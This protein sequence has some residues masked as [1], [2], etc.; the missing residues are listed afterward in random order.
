MTQRCDR[1]AV[2]REFKP[3][4]KVMVLLPI[5]GSALQQRCTGSYRVGEVNYVIA[6]PDRRKTSRLCHINM[7]KR[8]CERDAAVVIND[9]VERIGCCILQIV[10]YNFFSSSHQ[11]R[12]VVFKVREEGLRA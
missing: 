1:K 11:W 7:L 12:L 3:G 9:P 4:D 5:L 6:T 8:N 10:L 2:A